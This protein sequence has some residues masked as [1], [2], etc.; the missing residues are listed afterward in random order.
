MN[1][2]LNNVS[3]IY[4][5]DKEV[6]TAALRDV[7]LSLEDRGMVGIMGPSGSGKSSLLYTMAGLKIP[8][9]GQI[10]YEGKDMTAMDNTVL[11][12]LRR[13]EF[14]FIFQQHFLI[15]YMTIL[16]NA[17]V[18]L[19]LNDRQTRKKAMELLERLGIAK[20]AGKYPYQLSGGQRQRAAIVR[21]LM[22]DPKVIFGDEPTAALDHESAMEVMKLLSEY[23][24]NANV[25][26]VTHD[27]S[28]LKNADTMIHIEDGTIV[29]MDT[30][31]REERG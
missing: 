30:K 21:A 31:D 24:K 28:I 15:N 11:S 12:N 14:G 7:S 16:E 20:H 18:P 3:L 9:S 1:Y 19:N 4:D 5:M 6:K 23:T 26:I 25:V 17:L 10:L 29:Q 8:T 13:K 2:K 27:R 22:N